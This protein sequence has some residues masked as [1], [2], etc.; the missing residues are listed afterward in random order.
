MRLSWNL[1][2]SDWKTF[3]YQTTAQNSKEIYFVLS[4][5]LFTFA[6]NKYVTT[7]HEIKS[8]YDFMT[9]N[10]HELINIKQKVVFP[11]YI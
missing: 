7:M 1:S 8:V 2:D 9:E 3:I 10:L 4:R 5:I 6:Y 11:R